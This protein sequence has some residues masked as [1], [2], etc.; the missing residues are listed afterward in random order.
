MTTMVT[1]LPCQPAVLFY[2]S[3]GAT[4]SIITKNMKPQLAMCM[5]TLELCKSNRWLGE[6]IQPLNFNE[7]RKASEKAMESMTIVDGEGNL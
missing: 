5:Q 6:F 7:G 1:T 4:S 2:D 3:L